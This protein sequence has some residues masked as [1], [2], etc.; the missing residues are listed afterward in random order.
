MIFNGY[1]YFY[2]VYDLNVQAM[3][4]SNI[5]NY[6]TI[7]NHCMIIGSNNQSLCQSLCLC[8]ISVRI[9]LQNLNKYI[10]YCFRTFL[11]DYSQQCA[12][13]L[14]KEWSILLTEDLCTVIWQLGTACEYIIVFWNKNVNVLSD[15]AEWYCKY[16]Y[17][18]LCLSY[19]TILHLP[20]D[21]RFYQVIAL[22]SKKKKLTVILEFQTLF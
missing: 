3:P 11:K 13:I 18:E 19:D 8:T 10:I 1:I 16:K 7:T 17:I 12:W 21:K 5:H 2:C 15:K 6:I 14:Q 9:C 22:R 20:V 4:L